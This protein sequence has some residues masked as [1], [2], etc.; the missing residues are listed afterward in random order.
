MVKNIDVIQEF[1]LN[2][3]DESIKANNLFI[4]DNVLY[5][6]GYHYPLCIKIKDN[7]GYFYYLINK[8]G[9][10]QTTA[11]HTGDLIRELTN[12]SNFEELKKAKKQNKGYNHILLYSTNELKQIIEKI[13]Y[14]LNKTIKQADINDL[15]LLELEKNN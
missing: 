11:K 8:S 12:L 3:I 5:S 2:S 15:S 7:N 14:T 1:N 4:E 13:K 6:Y 9:Y 10:S